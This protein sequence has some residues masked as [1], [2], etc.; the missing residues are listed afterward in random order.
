MLVAMKGAYRGT[1]KALARR[2]S[3]GLVR[4][5]DDSKEHSSVAGTSTPTAC[6]RDTSPVWKMKVELAAAYRLLDK[7]KMNEGVWNHLTVA[8]NGKFDQ[9]LVPKKG[10]S[11][12]L[13]EPEDMLLV[14]STGKI[15]AGEGTSD[16]VDISALTIHAAVHAACG[17]NGVAVFHLH[18]PWSTTMCALGGEHGGRLLQVHQ[19]CARFLK[20][21]AYDDRFNGFS[22]SFAEGEMLAWHCV[23][24]SCFVVVPCSIVRQM[25]IPYVIELCKFDR[26]LVNPI[27]KRQVHRG[28]KVCKH[29][30]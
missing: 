23:M 10:L 21:I 8:V 15:I 5:D 30:C 27:P 28:L 18:M 25:G 19:N 22:D 26:L 6:N 3:P 12:S 7:H 24:Y 2:S 16:D 17:K 29:F 9:F 13:M 4:V 11:W 14:D 1:P 20:A